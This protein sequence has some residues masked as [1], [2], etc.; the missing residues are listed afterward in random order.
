ME[1]LLNRIT[2]IPDSLSISSLTTSHQICVG[3]VCLI[4]FISIYF[5]ILAFLL[6]KSIKYKLISLFSSSAVTF[7]IFIFAVELILAHKSQSL[8]KERVLDVISY[9]IENDLDT[10]LTVEHDYLIYNGKRYSHNFLYI[11]DYVVTDKN[12]NLVIIKD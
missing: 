12:G 10:E 6:E 3:V 2:D 1:E 5:L 11:G 7:L 8:Y 9:A 4:V